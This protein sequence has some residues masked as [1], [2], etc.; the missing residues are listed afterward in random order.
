ME[1]ARSFWNRTRESVNVADAYNDPDIAGALVAVRSN[2]W[3]ADVQAKA[4]ALQS[5]F[6]EILALV[7]ERHATRRPHAKLAR[8]FTALIPYALDT[9]F[10]WLARQA[11]AELMLGRRGLSLIEGGILSADRL[12]RILGKTGDDTEVVSRAQF[13]WWLTENK[14]AALAGAEVQ[15]PTE[16]IELA[17]ITPWPPTKQLRGITGDLIVWLG[18]NPTCAQH[19]D[20]AV[21]AQDLVG[22]PLLVPALQAYESLDHPANRFVAWLCQRVIKRLEVCDQ[23]WRSHALAGGDRAEWASARAA[24][25]STAA[26]T[27]RRTVRQTFL[28]SIPSSPPTEAAHLV[29]A[30][31]PAYARFHRLARLLLSPMF[32]AAGDSASAVPIRETYS[33]YELWCFLEVQR[34]VATALPGASWQAR[35]L[36]TLLDPGGTGA[37]A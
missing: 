9:C 5:H 2:P 28:H 31:E 6:D 8:A 34:R 15:P 35:N 12:H 17:P 14:S 32:D 4:K 22:A 26:Q 10:S 18:A 25:C 19:L 23:I 27:L 36:A 20:A 7:A 37:G 29:I 13:L 11:A 33:L 3:P 16:V 1:S 21:R 24:A 30:D